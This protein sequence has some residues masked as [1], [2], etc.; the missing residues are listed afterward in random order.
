MKPGSQSAKATHPC[1][2]CTSRFQ[3]CTV[4]HTLAQCAVLR[5]S[6]A[7]GVAARLTATV[8]RHN[9][10]FDSLLPIYD[11]LRDPERIAPGVFLTVTSRKPRPDRLAEP[12]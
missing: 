11:L 1:G 9:R 3:S 7:S 5:T 4:M 10:R 6:T 8:T 12:R 2:R